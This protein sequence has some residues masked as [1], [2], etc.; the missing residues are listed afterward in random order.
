LMDFERNKAESTK[1]K[2]SEKIKCQCF[3]IK[4]VRKWQVR[5]QTERAKQLFKT[6]N[7]SKVI[8]CPGCDQQESL[9][10]VSQDDHK[11]PLNSISQKEGK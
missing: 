6:I 10:E 5:P 11:R 2:E 9:F 7:W 8:V 3:A 1:R 4:L